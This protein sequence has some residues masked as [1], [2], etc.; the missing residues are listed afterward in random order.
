MA[1]AI[2]ATQT[3]AAQG[4]WFGTDYYNGHKAILSQ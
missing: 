2:L 3:I 1:M 4:Y